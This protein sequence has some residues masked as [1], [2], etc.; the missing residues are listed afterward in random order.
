MCRGSGVIQ[1]IAPHLVFRI[2]YLHL[3]TKPVDEKGLEKLIKMYKFLDYFHKNEK[4]TSSHLSF[5]GR[6]F[7]T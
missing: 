5:E 7:E 4:H 6:C 3:I 2:P 1:K